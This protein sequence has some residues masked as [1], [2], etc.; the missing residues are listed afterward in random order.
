MHHKGL[1]REVVTPIGKSPDDSIKLRVISRV[2][3]FGATQ[4]LTK[5]GQGSLGLVEDPFNANGTSITV[6]FKTEFKAGKNQYMSPA[7]LAFDCLKALQAMFVHLKLLFFVHLV[8][9]AM[10]ELKSLTN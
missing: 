10:M 1:R 8:K 7:K 2:V 9:G 4:L 6:N 3:E 5:V